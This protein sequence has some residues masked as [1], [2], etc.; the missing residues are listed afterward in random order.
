M[1]I[2]CVAQQALQLNI[3]TSLSELVVVE[4]NHLRHS[5]RATA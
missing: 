2:C 4:N 5:D 3:F 1:P